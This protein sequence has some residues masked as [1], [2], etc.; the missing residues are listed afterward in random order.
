MEWILL[1]QMILQEKLFLASQ[2]SVEKR[3]TGIAQELDNSEN[4][5]KNK[6][7]RLNSEKAEF[8]KS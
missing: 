6:I 3:L 7:N 2:S 5:S 4:L 1:S 8:R